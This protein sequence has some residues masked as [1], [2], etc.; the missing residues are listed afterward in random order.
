MTHLV[1]GKKKVKNLIIIWCIYTCVH[2]YYIHIVILLLLY[3]QFSYTT[4]KTE[5]WLSVNLH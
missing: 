2:I 1:K 4:F 5:L 3:S